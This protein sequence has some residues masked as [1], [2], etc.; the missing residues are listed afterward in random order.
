MN[1]IYFSL[2]VNK[3]SVT[4]SKCTDESNKTN[5]Y[6]YFVVVF[7]VFVIVAVVF[8]VIVFYMII[9]ATVVIATQLTKRSMK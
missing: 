3:I 1:E 8:V 2:F 9:F 5:K 6:F 7:V 4:L